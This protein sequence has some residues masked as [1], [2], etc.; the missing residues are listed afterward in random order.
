AS[1]SRCSAARRHA[2]AASTQNAPVR[3]TRSLALSI[4]SLHRSGMSRRGHVL[5]GECR[6]G[7]RLSPA[8]QHRS[9]GRIAL[10]LLKLRGC[11]RLCN[12]PKGISAKQLLTKLEIW[13]GFRHE[14]KSN[15]VSK[16]PL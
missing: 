11:D 1:S 2:L 5:A 7:E 14:L 10:P 4:G 16:K 13:F 3:S 8:Q 12:L 6:I 9:Q 15:S